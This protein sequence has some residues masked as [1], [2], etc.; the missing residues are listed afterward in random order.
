MV[1][2]DRPG[3]TGVHRHRRW[4]AGADRPVDTGHRHRHRYRRPSGGRRGFGRGGDRP[5]W[6]G[7]DPAFYRRACAAAGGLA[8]A[9]GP[10]GRWEGGCAC[11]R[12]GGGAVSARACGAGA[13]GGGRGYPRGDPGADPRCAGPWGHRGAGGMARPAAHGEGRPPAAGA[14]PPRA[15][16][17][18]WAVGGGPGAGRRYRP[19]RYRHRR[20]RRA[21][22]GR[23][24]GGLLEIPGLAAARSGH[25]RHG[26]G[27]AGRGRG[28]AGLAGADP[29]GR[30]GRGEPA[31]PVDA[32]RAAGPGRGGDHPVDR[33]DR[34]P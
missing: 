5:A 25:R 19:G 18:R 4:W 2:G 32:R 24:L 23:R 27:A 22:A 7:C 10:A 8:R 9:A 20:R 1:R 11:H 26:G 12:P 15:A 14:E 13:P 31:G 6:A 33:G 28:C 30:S 29:P 21:P 16:E 17:G 34:A 3:G